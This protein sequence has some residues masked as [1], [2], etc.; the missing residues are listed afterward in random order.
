[1]RRVGRAHVDNEGYPD[2]AIAEPRLRRNAPEHRNTPRNL[3]RPA[4]LCQ[5]A[6]GGGGEEPGGSS[7]P[8]GAKDKLGLDEGTEAVDDVAKNFGRV[9]LHVVRLTEAP[10]RPIGRQKAINCRSTTNNAT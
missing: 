9:R 7:P 1:M 10:G 8:R 2:V 5:F 6:G 4:L 3:D